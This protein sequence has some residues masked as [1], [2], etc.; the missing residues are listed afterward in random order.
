MDAWVNLDATELVKHISLDF[1]YDSQWVFNSM[2]A[3]E[4]PSYIKGKF[5]TSK[6][7]GVFPSVSLVND[8]HSPGGMLKLEQQG[9]P[10]GYLRIQCSEGLICKIDMSMC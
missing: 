6:R 3:E 2:Y 4:Y 7:T 5:E 8:T 1:Q 10:P 9:N